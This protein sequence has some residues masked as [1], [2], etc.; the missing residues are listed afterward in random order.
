M[1]KRG[2]GG[3]L[4][5]A[6]ENKKEVELCTKMYTDQLKMKNHSKPEQEH[7]FLTDVHE[8]LLKIF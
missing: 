2:G 5:E 7:L 4:F 1:E 6:L 8:F 3:Q